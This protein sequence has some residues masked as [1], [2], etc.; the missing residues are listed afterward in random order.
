M[1]Y[2]SVNP[3]DGKILKTFEELTDKQLE[4]AI[5]TAAPA[6]RPGGT[7]A[8]P[9]GRPWSRAPLPLCMSASRSSLGR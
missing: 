9:T 8:S 4:T 6:L 2:K 1:A 3:Y 5:E 7:R